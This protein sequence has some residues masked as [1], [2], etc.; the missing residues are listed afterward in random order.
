[1]IY[2]VGDRVIYQN[3]KG[4]VCG[5]YET[6]N[7]GII[8]E[9]SSKPEK[10]YATVKIKYDIRTNNGDLIN[11][12]DEYELEKDENQITNDFVE[13]VEYVLRNGL[14]VT[15]DDI[16][17]YL[18]SDDGITI[19]CSAYRDNGTCISGTDFDIIA[20]KPVSD[21]LFDP[22]YEDDEDQKEQVSIKKLRFPLKEEN[23]NEKINLSLS[24]K[25]GKYSLDVY[26]TPFGIGIM[27]DL[28]DSLEQIVKEAIKKIGDRLND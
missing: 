5:A 14:V 23:E 11:D 17:E 26:K 25:D 7:L 13:N 9:D 27:G 1:M 10:S 24:S 21:D 12:I 19:P 2:K 6:T 20:Q 22:C 18:K 3:K 16:E 4:I 15:Y 28:P 8:Q